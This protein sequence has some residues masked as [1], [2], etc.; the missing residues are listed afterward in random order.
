[1]T[2]SSASRIAKRKQ[3][4]LDPNGRPVKVTKDSRM[5]HEG[6]AKIAREM[7]GAY[8]ERA[9][10]RDDKWYSRFPNQ[11]DFIDTN[12]KNF[13][14]VARQSLGQMLGSNMYDDRTKEQ[15]YEILTLD[16][17]LPYAM[18]EDQVVNVH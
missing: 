15:V 2:Q 5:V 17:T 1:M 9:A 8:Y 7:A 18:N 6:V 4:I 11:Q 12:W 10:G 14:L 16:A 13:V 3:Q